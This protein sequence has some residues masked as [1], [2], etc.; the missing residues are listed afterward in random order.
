MLNIKIELYTSLTGI[1]DDACGVDVPVARYRI[2]AFLAENIKVDS[3]SNNLCALLTEMPV[4]TTVL[5][6]YAVLL[7]WFDIFFSLP[8]SYR[9]SVIIEVHIYWAGESA[10]I[11]SA[12]MLM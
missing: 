12:G 5:S 1:A 4:A 6:T 11:E 7:P 3:Q 2:A 10:G 8:H 9:D